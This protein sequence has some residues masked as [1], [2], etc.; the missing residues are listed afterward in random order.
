ML[1]YKTLAGREAHGEVWSP[2]P[3]YNTIW[4]LRDPD[5]QPVVVHATKRVEVEYTPPPSPRDRLDPVALEKALDIRHRHCMMQPH[6][7]KARSRS[8]KEMTLF[9]RPSEAEV[10]AAQYVY[11]WHRHNQDVSF[12]YREGHNATV[13]LSDKRFQ[14]IAKEAGDIGPATETQ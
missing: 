4:V 11:D 10:A 5:R 13:P 8:G 2:G 1:T 7:M 6:L 3:L 12:I 9:D 14:T